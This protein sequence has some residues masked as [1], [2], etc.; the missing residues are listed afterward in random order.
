[1]CTVTKMLHSRDFTF[2]PRNFPW[3][4]FLEYLEYLLL[5]ESSNKHKMKWNKIKTLNP[6][7]MSARHTDST[8]L[9]YSN[10]LSNI[11]SA[12]SQDLT[13]IYIP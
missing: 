6:K 2:E 4:F 13:D 1:M 3:H 9:S 7:H 8:Q 11:L 5:L 10:I 12:I